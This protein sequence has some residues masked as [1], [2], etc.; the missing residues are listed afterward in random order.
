MVNY[1][2]SPSSGDA[3]SDRQLTPNFELWVEI[4]CVPTCIHMRIPKPCLSVCPYHEKSLQLR[5]Y[6]SYISNWSINGKVFTS[7][8]AWKPQKLNFFSKKVEIEFWPVLKSWNHISFVNISPTLVIGTSMERSSWV[9]YHRIQKIWFYSK[10]H[11][12][13]IMATIFLRSTQ[14]GEITVYGLTEPAWHV[15]L[16]VEKHRHDYRLKHPQVRKKQY[17]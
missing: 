14:G 17:E 15:G 4:F 5:Q 2:A 1:Y 11:F 8:I 10:F 16:H 7:T 3:H 9:L 13:T 6:Q 12:F